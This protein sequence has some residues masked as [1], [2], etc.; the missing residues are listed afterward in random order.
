M[1]TAFA[2]VHRATARVLAHNGYDVV[3]PPDQAC[4]GALAVHAGEASS[5]RKLARRNIAA[6]N[7]PEFD[8][9]IVNRCRMWRGDERV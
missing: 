5:G 3:V 4:C 1:S 8:A 6:L 2:E 7:S 9:I